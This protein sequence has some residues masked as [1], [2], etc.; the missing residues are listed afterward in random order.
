M[1]FNCQ[2][3][4]SSSLIYA[5][6]QTFPE[7]QAAA[8]IINMNLTRNKEVKDALDRWAEF[9][10]ERQNHSSSF[11]FCEGEGYWALADMGS[12]IIAQMMLEYYN[13]KHGWWHELL[14][15]LVH[16]QVSNA[17]VF[18][19]DQIFEEWKDWFEHKDHKDAP[20]GADQRARRPHGPG[21][22]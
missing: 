10:I 15:E 22:E 14:H 12:S 8:D 20:Q 13:D 16:G 2:A 18:F 4:I 11:H 7:Q 3:Y 6:C 9:R 17:G 19:K 5:D 21:R 1:Y